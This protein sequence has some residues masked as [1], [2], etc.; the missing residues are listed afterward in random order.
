M[1]TR[2]KRWDGPRTFTIHGFFFNPLWFS[3][4]LYERKTRAQWGRLLRQPA[5]ANLHDWRQLSLYRTLIQ[6]NK[7][8]SFVSSSR[9]NFYGNDSSRRLE[10]DA[11]TIYKNAPS[12]QL[13]SASAAFPFLFQANTSIFHPPLFPFSLFRHI[14]FHNFHRELYAYI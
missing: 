9:A 12:S 10:R 6:Q 8:P 4:P 11:E 7:E 14:L 13:F 5:T 1:Y 2:V 3:F